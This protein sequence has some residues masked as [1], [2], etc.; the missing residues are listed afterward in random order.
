M[1]ARLKSSKQKWMATVISL[2]MISKSIQYCC[3]Q[4]TISDSKFRQRYS[5]LNITK[6]PSPSTVEWN[7]KNDFCSEVVLE[8]KGSCC[9]KSEVQSTI[10]NLVKIMKEN[11]SE[12]YN[13]QQDNL[14][15]SMQ[16]EEDYKNLRTKIQGDPEKNDKTKKL[17][18][19]ALDIFKPIY[20]SQEFAQ[21]ISNFM[22]GARICY[23]SLFTMRVN[24]VCLSCSSRASQYL[25]TNSKYSINEEFCLEV[26]PDCTTSM[27]G[28]FTV[29]KL[30][31]KG[32]MQA[33]D[34]SEASSE[35]QKRALEANEFSYREW[36]LCS[37]DLKNC[38]QNKYLF[39]RL[40]KYFPLM[41]SSSYEYSSKRLLATM[42]RVQDS[43][44]S[45]FLE[46]FRETNEKG[47]NKEKGRILQ[48]ADESDFDVS[49]DGA[50]LKFKFDNGFIISSDTGSTEIKDKTPL[51]S[52]YNFNVNLK[53]AVNTSKYSLVPFLPILTLI[54]TVIGLMLIY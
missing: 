39:Y 37:T 14:F 27:L 36:F 12:R 6:F 20:Q 3:P 31:A 40:C 53:A 25:W 5:Q 2:L 52:Q 29:S 28:L 22:K 35:T 16:T 34:A 45:Y 51:V 48:G 11:L 24:A 7:S 30:I 10:S 18:I 8:D 13:Q 41:K 23:Q 32:A 1:I 50:E 44:L 33:I 26:V 49:E 15:L 9:S 21:G 38:I 19:A 42:S 43:P 47:N 54:L 46:V 17:E 4:C